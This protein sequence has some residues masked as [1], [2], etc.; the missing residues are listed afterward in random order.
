MLEKNYP[1]APHSARPSNPLLRGKAIKIFQTARQ[2]ILTTYLPTHWVAALV[3]ALQRGKQR[4]EPMHV[5][6]LLHTHTSTSKPFRKTVSHRHF[7]IPLL[8][9]LHHSHSFSCSCVFGRRCS[10]T[11][12]TVYIALPIFYP[13]ISAVDEREEYY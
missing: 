2:V 4:L 10:S 9:V 13:C 12:T 3:S 5:L 8:Y 7:F 11:T 1:Y 6:Y